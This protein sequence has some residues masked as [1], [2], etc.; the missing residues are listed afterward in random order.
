LAPDQ[1]GGRTTRLLSLASSVPEYDCRLSQECLNT[2]LPPSVEF[3]TPFRDILLNVPV[4]GQVLV[5]GK[6]RIALA[7]DRDHASFDLRFAGTMRMIGTGNTH[8]VQVDSAFTTEFQGSKRIRCDRSG[9]RFLPSRCTAR[10]SIT[11]QG[12]RKVR[13]RILSRIYERVACRRANATAATAEQECSQHVE[14]GIRVFMDQY[15]VA[16]ADN[17]NIAFGDHVRGLSAEQN[18]VWG[19]VRCRTENDRLV[20]VRGPAHWS[21]FGDYDLRG[22]SLVIA[23]PRT[24]L[25]Q[26]AGISLP[27]LGKE[28]GPDFSGLFEGRR[29]RPS[30]ELRSQAIVVSLDILLLPED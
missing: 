29:L 8:G 22:K 25:G 9:I 27:F 26:N 12:I 13:P 4:H 30:V 19:Q 23:L 20:V 28:G 16:L 14:H 15:V 18:L 10:S 7:P 6:F 5:R 21:P 2:I 11:I 17:A 1:V 24:W 3:D